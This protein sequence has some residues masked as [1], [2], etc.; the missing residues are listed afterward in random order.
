MFRTSRPHSCL[1][2]TCIVNQLNHTLSLHIGIILLTY[3]PPALSGI[4][5]D[6]TR[7][8]NVKLLPVLVKWQCPLFHSLLF[9]LI[10]SPFSLT[11]PLGSLCVVFRLPL[12][13]CLSSS[14]FPT[15][16]F[17]SS[18]SQSSPRSSPPS[19]TIPFSLIF[20]LPSLAHTSSTDKDHC[21]GWYKAG[22][23]CIIPNYLAVQGN[24]FCLFFPSGYFPTKTFCFPTK[25]RISLLPI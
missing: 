4:E 23:G 13:T 2:H 11:L 22:P 24:A 25:Y 10:S 19:Y 7:S 21:W 3:I 1:S 12:H 16:R 15:L 20:N 5:L 9:L 18:I 8:H 17:S 14:P 6:H